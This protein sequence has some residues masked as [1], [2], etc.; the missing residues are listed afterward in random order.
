MPSA[1]QLVHGHV[2]AA[3]VEAGEHSVPLETVAGN[4]ITEAVRILKQHRT[5]EDIASELAFATFRLVKNPRAEVRG[6]RE[7]LTVRHEF[8]RR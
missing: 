8:R 5:K 7:R 1:Y 2:A 6:Q 3:L 4:L